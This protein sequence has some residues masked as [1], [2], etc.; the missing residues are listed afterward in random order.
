[1]NLKNIS[2][3]AAIQKEQ[4]AYGNSMTSKA[5]GVKIKQDNWSADK[6]PYKEWAEVGI[7]SL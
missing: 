7:V 5:Y 6:S 4:L 1:M 2:P 3:Y